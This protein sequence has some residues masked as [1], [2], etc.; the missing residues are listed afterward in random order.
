MLDRPKVKF[1]WPA[2]L[3]CVPRPSLVPLHSY[4]RRAVNTQDHIPGTQCVLLLMVYCFTSCSMLLRLMQGCVAAPR[5]RVCCFASCKGVLPRLMQGCVASPHARVCCF[6]SCKGVLLR[7]VQGCVASPRASVC[8]LASCKGVL[9]R[10]FPPSKM[11][12][13]KPNPHKEQHHHSEAVD[14]SEL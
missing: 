5:A 10:L 11:P 4:P 9:L 1:L 7:L 12:H 14:G 3:Q 2:S 6:A 8:C 13:H